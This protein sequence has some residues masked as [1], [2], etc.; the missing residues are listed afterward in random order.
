MLNR[1]AG[2]Q[3]ELEYRLIEEMK[4]E[5]HQKIT[6]LQKQK[7]LLIKQQ[8]ADNSH[9]SAKNS[10]KIEGLEQQLREWRAKAKEQKQL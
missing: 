3:M 5:Y 6:E 4:E 2:Q 9:N 8:R 7:S 1:M 10:V